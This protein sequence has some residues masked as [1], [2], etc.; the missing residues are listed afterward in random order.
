MDGF[1]NNLSATMKKTLKMENVIEG[2]PWG[3]RISIKN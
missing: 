1:V 3:A 2:G